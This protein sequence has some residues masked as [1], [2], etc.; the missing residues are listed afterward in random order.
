MFDQRLGERDDLAAAGARGGFA[1]LGC[2]I[3]NFMIVSFGIQCTLPIGLKPGWSK[4]LPYWL[5]ACA[6]LTRP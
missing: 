2:G 4:W 1:Q 5:T 3:V 6:T